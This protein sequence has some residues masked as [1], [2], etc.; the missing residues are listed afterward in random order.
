MR[1]QRLDVGGLRLAVYE[2]GA[3]NAARTVVCAHGLT[4]NGRDFDRLAEALAATHRVIAFDFAGRG[5]SDWLDDPTAYG[6]PTY[7]EHAVKLAGALGLTQVDW[8]GTSMGGILGMMLAASGTGFIR[9][10]VLND[11][12]SFIPKD[13]IK[14]ILTAHVR[15]DGAFPSRAAAE[16]AMRAAYAGFGPMD[17]AWWTH[18][19]NTSLH[20]LPSGECGAVFDPAIFTPLVA[21]EPEDVDLTALWAATSCPTLLLRGAQS[22]LLTPEVAAAMAEREGV[23]LVEVPACGHAPSLSQP[24]QIK[25]VVDYLT[26]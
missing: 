10:L 9:T 25:I 18:L 17:E 1:E 13:A 3:S 11:V 12:G 5:Q 26:A 14:G 8:V 16:Q 7:V 23:T 21:A 4:R 22:G 6:Y 15:H 20:N 19:F 24:D 2:W